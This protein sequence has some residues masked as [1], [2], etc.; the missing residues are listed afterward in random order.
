MSTRKTLK[1]ILNIIDVRLNDVENVM[2]IFLLF[3]KRFIRLGT[4]CLKQSVKERTY[5]V[6]FG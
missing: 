4:T 2:K 1:D 5:N 3:Y 6:Y